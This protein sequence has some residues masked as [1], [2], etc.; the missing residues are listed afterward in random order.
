M[1]SHTFYCAQV[2]KADLPLP[3]YINIVP[4]ADASLLW[5]QA[6][7]LTSKL[8]GI[9]IAPETNVVPGEKT[10]FKA[11]GFSSADGAKVLQIVEIPHIINNLCE[12]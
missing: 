10:P 3:L 11:T 6:Q 7:N 9:K 2:V 1:D 5:Q 4:V 8:D 12:E